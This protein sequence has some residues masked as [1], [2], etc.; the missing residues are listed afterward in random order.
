MTIREF[1]RRNGLW[2]VAVALLAGGA[3]FYQLG[4]GVLRADELNRFL[5]GRSPVGLVEFWRDWSAPDQVPL[6]N[7]FCMWVARQFFPEVNEYSLRVP[8]AVLGVLT[9]LLLAG[10]AAWHYGRSAG[11]FLG[12]WLSLN[13][14]HLH[15]SREA[16]YYG[17]LMFNG[18]CF[19]LFTLE[20]LVRLQRTKEAFG[21][22]RWG[23]W[24]ALTILLRLA[25]V[26]MDLCGGLRNG[27]AAGQSAPA[28]SGEVEES[29]RPGRSGRGGSAGD[30]A[31]DHQRRLQRAG[32]SQRQGSRH[33]FR[34]PLCGRGPPGAADVS[35]Q[36]RVAGLDAAAA[37]AGIGGL[38][39][40]AGAG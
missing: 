23:G 29:G 11:I 40:D 16:Y 24:T 33:F 21:W 1:I 27:A 32:R 25:H 28:G 9:V 38:A 37:D 4:E 22:F 18:A 3:R 17:M 30:A 10:W 7:V 26:H 14:Y 5:E 2:L 36:F 31:L 6:Q 12:I 13:P 35:R 19:S 34:R 15:E 8:G 20:M 39:L